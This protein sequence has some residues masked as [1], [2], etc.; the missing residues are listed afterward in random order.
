[1]T[2]ALAG[3]HLIAHLYRCKITGTHG[4]SRYSTVTEL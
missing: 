1:M 3:E 4:Q 2:V